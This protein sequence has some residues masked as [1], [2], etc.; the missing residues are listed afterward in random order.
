MEISIVT[1]EKVVKNEL[2][3]EIPD[4]LR[5]VFPMALNPV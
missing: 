1:L 5:E 3:E 4:D 2:D